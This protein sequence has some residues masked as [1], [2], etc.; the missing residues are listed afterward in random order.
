MAP[1]SQI[2]DKT[3][4]SEKILLYVEKSNNSSGVTFNPEEVDGDSTDF[5]AFKEI[6]LSENAFHFKLRL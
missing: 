1:L 3:T 4:I 5:N 2:L 6:Y